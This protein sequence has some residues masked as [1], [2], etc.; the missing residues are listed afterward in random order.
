MEENM[1]ITQYKYINCLVRYYAAGNTNHV[2]LFDID[3]L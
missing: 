1:A 3:L 2:K